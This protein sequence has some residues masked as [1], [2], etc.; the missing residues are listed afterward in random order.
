MSFVVVG[1]VFSRDKE[2]LHQLGTT[3]PVLPVYLER[4]T[5]EVEGVHQGTT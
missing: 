5:V 3:R 1:T 2:V 4:Y